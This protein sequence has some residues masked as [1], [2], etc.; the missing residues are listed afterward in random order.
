MKR[1]RVILDTNVVLAAM[2]SRVGASHHLLLG[3]GHPRWQAI[4][5]PALM[6]EYGDVARRPGAAPGL[7]PED[8]T[9]ILDF[10]YQQSQRK[11]VWFSYRPLSLDPGDDAVL[12]AAIAGSCDYVVSFNNKHLYAAKK[13]GIEILKPVELLRLIGEIK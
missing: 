6:Y 2:R 5:T 10:I 3:M 1:Y 11:M 9:N 4:V 13:F 8:I 7:S 12:E